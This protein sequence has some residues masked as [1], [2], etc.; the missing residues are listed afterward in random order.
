MGKRSEDFGH[1][2]ENLVYLELRRR[3]EVAG[4]HLTASGREVD[5]V[6]GPLDEPQLVQACANLGDPDTR[7]HE[8]GALA[9][10]MDELDCDRGTVVTLEESAKVDHD[11]RSIEIVPAWQWL[12][13]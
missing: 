6:S 4:Y 11:G 5:F 10:A 2:L 8:L 7:E 3:G 1:H 12:L 9:E 13:A